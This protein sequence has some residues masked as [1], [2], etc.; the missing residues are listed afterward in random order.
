[1]AV[2]LPTVGEGHIAEFDTL[3]QNRNCDGARRIGYFRFTFQDLVETLDG[4]TASLEQ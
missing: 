1:M 2:C 3:S 4:G